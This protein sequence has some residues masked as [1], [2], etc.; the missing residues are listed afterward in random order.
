MFTKTQRLKLKINI[1][2]KNILQQ[3]HKAHKKKQFGAKPIS[4]RAYF[5]QNSLKF[6]EN[7]NEQFTQTS[8]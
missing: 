8:I 7:F 5:N 1:T 6:K 3:S 2:F 4:N